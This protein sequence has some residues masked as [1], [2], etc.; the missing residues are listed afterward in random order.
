MSMSMSRL[1]RLRL[2]VGRSLDPP[3]IRPLHTPSTAFTR[4]SS[5]QCQ[6]RPI[7]IPT[8]CYNS[9]PPPPPPLVPPPPLGPRPTNRLLHRADG[10]PRSKLAGLAIAAAAT[11]SFLVYE[12]LAVIDELDH[13]VH[14]LA[15]LLHVQRADYRLFASSDLSSPPQLLRLYR[16]LQAPVNPALEDIYGEVD[17][18][19]RMLT[20]RD[21]KV[22]EEVCAVLRDACAGVHAILHDPLEEAHELAAAAKIVG[23]LDQSCAEL[24]GILRRR[25]EA[26]AAAAQADVGVGVRDAGVGVRDSG[27]AGVGEAGDSRRRTAGEEAGEEYEVVG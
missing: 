24:L 12:A 6:Q 25:A 27:E 16:A 23:L 22:Y 11:L 21:E 20:A 10:T 13:G 18:M 9:A 26:E 19:C 17:R 7:H 15:A 2:R 14:L 5:L 3:K 4:Q 1:Q 8:R